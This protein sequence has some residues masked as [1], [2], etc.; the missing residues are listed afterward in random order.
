MFA[1]APVVPAPP[2]LT[3]VDGAVASWPVGS[4]AV[5]APGAA[6][7]VSPLTPSPSLGLP[8][9]SA[10]KFVKLAGLSGP[11]GTA[12]VVDS[13]DMSLD[14]SA[15]V[16]GR[17]L[18]SKVGQAPLVVGPVRAGGAS[19]VARGGVRAPGSVA[20]SVLG[21]KQAEA[22]GLSVF[23]FR[24]ADT[25]VKVDAV[26]A[27]VPAGV[28]V[29]IDYSS[30]RYLYGA[31]W[32]GRLQLVKFPECVLSTPEVRSCST[33]TTY[34]YDLN[35]NRITVTDPKNNVTTTTYDKLGRQT[36]IIDPDAGTST[37]TYNANSTLA[38]T[39][40]PIATLTYTTDV[41]GR[42]TLVKNGATQLEK[43]VY[44]KAG[45]AGLLDYASSFYNGAELK[46]DTT[47]Y[48]TRNR[49][50]GINYVIPSIAGYTDTNGFAGTYSYTGI[51][52]DRAD[53]QTAITY[54]TIGALPGET[55]TTAYTTLGYPNTLTT[56]AQSLV[57]GS[58]YNTN[59]TLGSRTFDVSATQITA[60]YSYE[61][62]TLRLN[63][64][65]VSRN[66]VFVGSDTT[67]Y[68][69]NG[70]VK[71][72]SHD[73]AGTASDHAECYGYDGRNQIGIG[74]T[75][76]GTGCA[77]GNPGT[78]GDYNQLTTV[79]EIGN[80]TS[81]T[82]ATSYGPAGSYTYAATVGTRTLP[83]APS[84]AGTTTFT[85]RA[86]GTMN[87]R[88]TPAG[89][90]TYTWDP[91]DRLI[92]VA[93]PG[94]TSNM[95][96]FAGGERVLMKDT[97][98]VHLYLGGLSERNINTAT[99]VE[100]RYFT[101]NGTMVATRTKTGTTPIVY[102]YLFTDTRGSNTIS[103][104]KCTD[105][106]CVNNGQ[107]DTHW[108]TP[109][110]ATRG[111]NTLT[112]TNRG[113]IGQYQDTQ[114]NLNYLHNRYYDPTTGIFLSVDPLVGATGTP[115]LYSGGNPTT[116][117]DPSGLEPCSHCTSDETA[118][119]DTYRRMTAQQL[120]DAKQSVCFGGCAD[121]RA[122]DSMTFLD[123]R[124]PP[125]ARISGFWLVMGL[126]ALLTGGAAAAGIAEAGGAGAVA[127]A[128]ATPF[129]HAAT[130]VGVGC[131]KFCQF[132]VDAANGAPTGESPITPGEATE[133][134]YT[135]SKIN[136]TEDGLNH[137]F[138]R[139]LADGALSA[140]KSLFNDNVT[141]TRL[142]ADADAVVPGVQGN[143]NLAY[144]VDAGRVIGV[145]RVTGQATSVYTVITKP[146]GDLVT[147]FPGTP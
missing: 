57:T 19:V 64:Q 37:A 96:Y 112:S 102:H 70:N 81:P 116:L 122:H 125:P 75:N 92:A 61:A 131:I 117:S 111:T 54:P 107:T 90:T 139:H 146:G 110:G 26:S 109:F 135:A 141:I 3:P 36:S 50:T 126:A 121:N 145:D 62:G 43:Y 144:V 106:N 132:L 63:N 18:P 48:D 142:I 66:G 93:Q 127:T 87:T 113:Y 1:V 130:T 10:P 71:I 77:T 20:V 35:G 85:Y 46:I 101:L 72:T 89:V 15:V 123:K 67:G 99:P 39:T 103:I 30:F 4:G 47:G 40:T 23:G 114:T 134:G 31:D 80:F 94:A 68:D 32:A 128:A 29:E 136:I 27:G 120:I 115:Y 78:P 86:D 33:I 65:T 25:S 21:T 16:A 52:Y 14:L 45:E 73:R 49:P 11:V 5:G 82:G 59:G 55:V 53:H 147:A 108:Y 133:A 17:G 98:G 129:V 118:I 24:L 34:T 9:S 38:T 140:G 51:T 2:V 28:H 12:A 124:R 100:N 79:D 42:T 7:G 83:H 104:N 69:A 88:T 41:L 13:A 105:V 76:N 56:T 6:V 91:F 143:G 95:I 60:G 137:V 44:D 138:D 58:T 22:V 119:S 97:Q 8:A 74:Y 84:Q